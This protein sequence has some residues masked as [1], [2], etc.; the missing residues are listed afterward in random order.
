MFLVK[1][2][3][4][5]FAS[6][7]FFLVLFPCR[8]FLSPSISLASCSGLARYYRSL[9]Q[10]PFLN[11]NFKDISFLSL[12]N[13]FAERPRVAR[14]LY[15][16]R[17]IEL[18]LFLT[19]LSP[20]FTLQHN[21]FSL[22]NHFGKEP[23]FYMLLVRAHHMSVTQAPFSLFYIQSFLYYPHTTN[24]LSLRNHFGKGPGITC[25]LHTH[26][27]VSV[28]Q[29]S[30]VFSILYSKLSLFPSRHK[31]PFTASSAS[32]A[33]SIYNLK[34][35][36]ISLTAQTSFRCAITLARALVHVACANNTCSQYRLRSLSLFIFP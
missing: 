22:R 17:V 2:L 23:S 32:F 27:H 16:Q 3:L 36:S 9:A 11:F 15:M 13:H 5:C 25:H 26:T 21:L 6:V 28:T 19:F 18:H 12:H 24:L 4:R 8:F 29:A 31:P 34:S 1:I 20:L 35:F 30:L 10:P 14:H 7:F 33:F